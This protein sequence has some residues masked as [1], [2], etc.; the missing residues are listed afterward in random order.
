MEQ[1]KY[2]RY[3]ITDSTKTFLSIDA[4]LRVK[5]IDLS[6]SGLAFQFNPETQTSNFSYGSIINIQLKV[7][8]EN[9]DIELLAEIRWIMYDTIGVEYKS[10]NNDKLAQIEKIIKLYGEEKTELS[11]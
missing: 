3:N 4:K 6:K 8:S 2:P 9:I 1:R 7:P 11:F 5:L 10:I